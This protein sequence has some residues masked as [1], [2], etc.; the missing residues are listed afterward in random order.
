[1]KK[2]GLSRFLALALCLTLLLGLVPPVGA[3]GASD[4]ILYPAFTQVDN[5]EVSASLP[6]Q[7]VEELEEPLYADTDQVRVSIVLEKEST[8]EAGFSTQGIGSNTAAMQYREGLQKD[9]TAATASIEKNALGGEKLDVVWNLTLAANIISANVPYGKL[10]AIAEVP[11]VKAV[12]LETRYEPAVVTKPEGEVSPNMAVSTQM[13]GTNTVW[14][15]GYTG[16]GTR[17]AIIDTGLDTDHQSFSPEAFDY[18]I[19]E[20]AAKEGLSAEAYR[21][22]KNFLDAEE[23]AGVMSQLNASRRY[24][25]A[26]AEDFYFSTKVPF[27]YNYIDNSLNITHF[28]ENIFGEE[29]DGQ[30]SHGSHVAGIAAANRY[31]PQGD[32]YAEAASTVQ[33]VGNA[34]DAQLIVL[35]VFGVN[36]GAYESD[37]FAA[38]EDAIVLGCDSVN[39]SLGSVDAGMTTN[40]VYQEIMDSLEKTDTVVTMSAGNNGNWAESSNVPK[41]YAE[42]V[43][44]DTMGSPGSYTN[45]LAVAS[46]DNDGSIGPYL[47]LGDRKIAYTD[48]LTGNRM[49]SKMDTTGMGAEYEYLLIDGVGKAEDYAGMDVTGKIV[50]CSRGEI[51]FADKANVANRDLG[52]AA[53]VVYNNEPGVIN[54]NLSSYGQTQPV[55]A[56]TQADG[57]AVKAAGT[58][59]TTEAGLTY[60]TGTISVHADYAV[61]YHDSPYLNM[62]S[63][64]SWGIPSDLSMK[65]EITAPGGMVYSVN[66]YQLWDH[67]GYELMSGTSMA[68]PQ[69]AGMAALVKQY[70]EENDLHQEELTDRA[71][72][73]SLLMSTAIPLMEEASGNYYSILRQGAGLAAVDQ[74]VSAVSYLTV[75]G[76]NDGKVKAELGDDPNRTGEYTFAFTL[77]DLSGQDFAYVLSADLFTQAVLEGYVDKA[78]TELGL[79]MDTLTDTM[80]ALASFQVDGRPV[81]P[82]EDLTA[83]DFN[84]DKVTDLL[85]AQLLM[86]HVLGTATLEGNTDVNGDGATTSLDVHA[87]LQILSSGIVTVPA[88]GSVTVEVTLTLTKEQK[89]TLDA[90]FINGAYVEGFVRVT[91]VA[92]AEGLLAPVH[93]IPVLAFYG[94]WSDPSM[95]DKGSD[96]TFDTGDLTQQHYVA[97]FA[98]TLVYSKPNKF[99]QYYLGGNPVVTD[100]TYM[101]ERNAWNNS[102]GNL[103]DAMIMTLIRNVGNSRVTVT[104]ADTGEILHQKETGS[105]RAAFYYPT[106]GQ[107]YNTNTQFPLKYAAEGIAEGTRLAVTIEAA[108]EYYVTAEGA[109]DWEALGNGASFTT[110]FTIDNT[111][112]EVQEIS[113]NILSDTLTVYAQDNRYVAGA[114]LY[115][116]GGLALITQTGSNQEEAGGQ[117]ALT[118]DVSGVSGDGFL[119][120]V[121]D[122][123]GNAAVYTLDLVMGNPVRMDALGYDMLSG[124]FVEFNIGIDDRFTAQDS[125]TAV[126]DPDL[127]FQAASDV[128]GLMY[129]STPEGALYVIDE[130][131]LE[132]MTY[133][134]ELG[135][136]LTDMAYNRQDGKLYGITQAGELYTVDPMNAIVSHVATISAFPANTLAIDD[137]GNFY[138]LIY[139]TSPVRLNGNTYDPGTLCRF[140]LDTVDSPEVVHPAILRHEG[141]QALEWDPNTGWIC[142]C[143]YRQYGT[144]NSNLQHFENEVRIFDLESGSLYYNYFSYQWSSIVTVDMR[145]VTAMILPE[146]GA[147]AQW[148]KET[149]EVAGVRVNASLTLVPGE[150]QLLPAAVTPW[151]VTDRTVTW[152][153]SDANVASVDENGTITANRVGTATITA[154]SNLDPTK[155]AACTVTVDYPQVQLSGIVEND[156]GESHLFTWDL[157]RGENYRLGGKIDVSAGAAVLDSLNNDLYVASGVMDEHR[158]YPIYQVDPTTGNITEQST[159]GTPFPLRGMAYLEYYSTADEIQVLNIDGS[160]LVLSPSEPMKPNYSSFGVEILYGN[161]GWDLPEFVTVASGGISDFQH[162]SYGTTAADLFY[163]LDRSGNI[164]TAYVYKER[165]FYNFVLSK[166]FSKVISIPSDLNL[167]HFDFT[168]ADGCSNVSMWCDQTTGTLYLAYYT[169]T[170]T[171][172]WRLAY[173]DMTVSY[174]STLL[175]TMEGVGPVRLYDGKNLD[176]NATQSSTGDYVATRSL[177]FETAASPEALPTGT[178]NTASRPQSTQPKANTDVVKVPLTIPEAGTNGI[179]T[180]TYDPEKVTL[181]SIRG[182]ADVTRWVE[183]GGTVKLGYA[184]AAE[185]PAGA[186]FAELTLRTKTACTEELPVTFLER[187]QLT[188]EYPATVTLDFGHRWGDWAVTQ[189]PGCFHQG[190]KTRTC[191]VCGEVEAAAIPANGDNCSSRQFTDLNTARWYHPYTDYVIETGLMIGMGDDKFAP[192]ATLTRGMLVTTLYRLAGEPQVTK[193]STFTDLRKGAYYETAVA[194][195]QAEGI[196]K[197]VT[198]KLF[199]PGSPVTR[200]QAAT[201]LY[202]YVTEYLGKTPAA[203]GDLSGFRDAAKLSGFAQAPVAWAVAEGFLEGFGDGTL[204]PRDS[205]TRAQMA[206]FLTI[207]DKNF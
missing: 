129:A 52:A 206:K 116:A 97:A 4:E 95:F 113:Y 196:V 40:A 194:W 13:N 1:M 30:S 157:S 100:E 145:H 9:Q 77:H 207:L 65:P 134:G 88:N 179:V 42:D 198:D 109:T 112:P 132:N 170:D 201:F 161:L 142:W 158:E 126:Y 173:N 2:S 163:I 53:L 111:A 28:C 190:E 59:K 75:D 171:E 45:S 176:P 202:R 20:N 47:Q 153:S 72:V 199:A 114:Q 73:Q 137:M 48:T 118:M 36:G 26:T 130:A 31:I 147:A 15:M 203:G 160:G 17:I 94:N 149:N 140:T 82:V 86:D 131:N 5:S 197:G 76:Q 195:A 189:K 71:L 54:M 184:W 192:D 87:L 39:L 96:Q 68:A 3:E 141:P 98:N 23:I 152:S 6:Q 43:N 144:H 66:G 93:T 32:G 183:D 138:T 200:E 7:E 62:S 121:L 24:P 104:N 58:A 74:A 64:S 89:E 181:E 79:Y 107:W 41:L 177:E 182:L 128:N 51:N 34:P 78:E 103:L 110:S 167:N 19:A 205:L 162:T 33:M 143:L 46:V 169:G 12:V 165:I 166:Q 193:D 188:E 21:K 99:T 80:D 69:M 67:D 174:E 49:M 11:G 8:V 178:L 29:E 168:T 50:F 115:R 35:K 57:A 187:N 55:V 151:T 180:F 61:M 16:A 136:P 25:A 172:I 10:E 63:F 133:V 119:L 22:Q 84:G 60:Y 154:T 101:E 159:A 122:Y 92:T 135:V 14:D 156:D 185:A 125:L 44:L 204:G 127:A 18:A 150:S 123:A 27:G 70:I 37:Y 56:I 146:K 81:V 83:W 139:G 124:Q 85:D 102:T 38:M 175:T 155:S 106:A 108:P 120:R 105:A 90:N 186:A 117:A 191:Q 164:F 148:P 91:P